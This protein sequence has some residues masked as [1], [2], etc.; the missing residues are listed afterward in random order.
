M[1][2]R[3]KKGLWDYWNKL[4]QYFQEMGILGFRCDA[5]Y[6]VP[7]DLWKFLISAAKKTPPAHRVSCRDPRLHAGADCRNE[8]HG[9]RLPVQF[10]EILEFDKP[11]CLEQHEENKKNRAVNKL[12]RIARHA[13]ARQARNRE[14]WR[15]RKCGMLLRR[16]FPGACSC[17]QGMNTA[18]ETEWML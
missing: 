9:F 18:P 4:V 8:R 5:A 16:Y 12:S 1:R 7:A 11:W 10:L 3:T 15:S 14:R 17:P 13:K 6:Q 2:A